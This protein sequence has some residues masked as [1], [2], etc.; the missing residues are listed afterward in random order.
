VLNKDEI[1]RRLQAYGII[2][3]FID[4]KAPID[5]AVSSDYQFGTIC[6]YVTVTTRDV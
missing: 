1:K 4:R 5:G 2:P 3:S 6:R